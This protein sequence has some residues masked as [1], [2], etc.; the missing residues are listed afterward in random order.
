M[1]DS[2]ETLKR[3]LGLAKVQAKKQDG[4]IILYNTTRQELSRG[5]LVSDLDQAQKMISQYVAY[6]RSVGSISLTDFASDHQ[7]RPI[8][9]QEVPNQVDEQSAYYINKAASMSSVDRV[10]LL[11]V[12]KKLKEQVHVAQVTR[13]VKDSDVRRHL[14]LKKV[15]A[16]HLLG[17][18]IVPS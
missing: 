4:K 3:L 10:N 8:P 16:S 7:Y 15:A 13:Q 2:T 6:L 9:Y 5:V 12:A 11:L 14:R 1:S 18:K 17:A